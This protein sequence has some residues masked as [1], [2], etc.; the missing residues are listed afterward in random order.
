LDFARFTIDISS[1]LYLF[2]MVGSRKISSRFLQ[3]VLEEEMI[4]FVVVVDSVS[5]ESFRGAKSLVETLR[6]N[7]CLP[8]PLV[9]AANKQDLE[10][11]WST[12]DLRILLRIPPEIPVI[13]CVATDKKSVAS[14]LIGLCEEVLRSWENEEAEN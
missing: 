9:I 6:D 7:P 11:A 5:P 2:C 4:G 10:D 1:V 3:E 14:V 13:P 8:Y 12:G